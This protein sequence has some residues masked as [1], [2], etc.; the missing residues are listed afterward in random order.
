METRGAFLKQ[1]FK[2]DFGKNN[3]HTSNDMNVRVERYS[4]RKAEERPVTG[5]LSLR[6][7]CSHCCRVSC[8]G[9][10]TCMNLGASCC[11][12]MALPCAAER[13]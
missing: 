13:L 6:L 8:C 2:A 12:P 11:R 9:S 7:N 1:W 5:R 3:G 4:G 10:D